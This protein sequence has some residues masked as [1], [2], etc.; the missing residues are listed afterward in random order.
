[1]FTFFF[2]DHAHPHPPR[3]RDKKP[4]ENAHVNM[5]S[6]TDHAYCLNGYLFLFG[7]FYDIILCEKSATKTVHARIRTFAACKNMHYSTHTGCKTFVL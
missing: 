2:Y 3:N 7:F 4:L 5:T 1:M 6:T